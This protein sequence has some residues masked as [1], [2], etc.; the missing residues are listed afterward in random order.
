MMMV[1][2]LLVW[3]IIS[4]L[5]AKV[6]IRH[7]PKLTE[8][9]FLKLKKNYKGDVIPSSYG[10]LFLE[11]SLLLVIFLAFYEI[12]IEP[13]MNFL[14]STLLGEIYIPFVL[15]IFGIPMMGLGGLYDDLY[16]R[17]E[18]KGFRGHFKRLFKEGRLTTGGAKALLGGG[19]SLI[20]GFII[21]VSN[22]HFNWGMLLLNAGIIALTTNTLNL[23][24]LRPGRAIKGFFLGMV[25]VFLTNSIQAFWLIFFLFPLMASVLV[26]AKI[27]FKGEAMMGDVGSNIL[28]VALG[29]SI[30]WQFS[31]YPKLVI[32]LGLILFH[33]YC[34]FYSLSE[35]IE[36]NKVLHFLDRLETKG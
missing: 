17:E 26:Y 24:D 22:S 31:L 16:G 30:A 15:V 12:K 6:L 19:V 2:V 8:N 29:I 20:L 21:C 25:L 32:L 9:G 36:K 3:F 23:L 14:G 7:C 18:V 4:F 34:E 28:G 5:L 33:I 1:F 10:L 11:S 27:D 35:L 13:I